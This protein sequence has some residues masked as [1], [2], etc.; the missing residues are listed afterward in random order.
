MI[1]RK[2][3]F[4][5]SHWYHQIENYQTSA[6]EYYKLVEEALAQRKI[7]NLRISKV[8]HREGGVLSTKREYLRVERKE[9]IFDICAAPFGTGFFI[10]WWLGEAPGFFT[11]LMMRIPV[12]GA[13]FLA[14]LKPYTYYRIDTAL[15]FQG[16]VHSAVL[17]VID[18]LLQAK[19]LRALSESERKPIL[20]EF[21]QRIG[22]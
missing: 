15:M 4:I 22:G 3:S 21:Y 11:S 16:L 2:V 1:R 12:I 13:L 7:P 5:I 10:S 19:G 6:K 20:R 8:I 17:E 14:L 18:G 9:H